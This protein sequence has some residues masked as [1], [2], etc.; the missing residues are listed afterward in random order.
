MHEDKFTLHG[1][2]IEGSVLVRPDGRP[3]RRP[4]WPQR[5]EDREF[6]RMRTASFDPPDTG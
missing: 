5:P 3:V 1:N 6:A 4:P 2:H